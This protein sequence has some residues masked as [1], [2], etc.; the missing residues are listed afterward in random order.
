MIRR[1]VAWFAVVV[2]LA[3][4]ASASAPAFAQDADTTEADTSTVDRILEEQERMMSGERFSYDPAGRRDPFRSLFETV[5]VKEGK[6]PEGISGMLVT[7]IDL[8]GI[9]KDPADGDVA[10]FSGT[11]NKG[12]FLQVGDEVFDG[13]LIAISTRGGSVTFRQRV[14]DPR[15]IKPYRDVEKHLIPLEEGSGNE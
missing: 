4:V 7:E 2:L 8:V 11:D 1:R 10:F 6:R 3:L 12:Y 5:R 13:T 9:V 14:D 15:R